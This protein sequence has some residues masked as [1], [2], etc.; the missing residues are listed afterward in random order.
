MD[1]SSFRLALNQKVFHQCQ[2]EPNLQRQ[3]IPG[4]MESILPFVA[5]QFAV[6]LGVQDADSEALCNFQR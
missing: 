1:E 6:G 2:S 3:A 5:K 4:Q